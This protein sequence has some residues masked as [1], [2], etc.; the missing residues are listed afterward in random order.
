MSSMVTTL[1]VATRVLPKRKRKEISYKESSSDESEADDESG[2]SDQYSAKT[3][4]KV[5]YS[6]PAVF[7]DQFVI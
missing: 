1:A 7:G 2:A 6:I 4:S 3:A 5:R